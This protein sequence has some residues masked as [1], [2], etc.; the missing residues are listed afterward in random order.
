MSLNKDLLKYTISLLSKRDYSKK[1][2]YLK[3]KN[4]NYSD[5]EIN[6]VIDFLSEKNYLNDS[7]YIQNLVKKY[8]ELGKS[9]SYIYQKLKLKGLNKNDVETFLNQN[10]ETLTPK[11]KRQIESKFK[12]DLDNWN[13]LD[14]YTKNKIKHFLNNRHF[15]NIN[16]L[17]NNYLISKNI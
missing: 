8:T 10:D 17:V 5:L 4:K 13:N 1:E 16:N 6:S 9:N 7:R 2:I 12:C 15:K 11:L 3:S 14:Y